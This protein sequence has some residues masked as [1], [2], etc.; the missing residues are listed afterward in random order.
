MRTT[1]ERLARYVVEYPAEELPK[2]T[3]EMARRALLDLLGCA[4]AGAP[5]SSARAARHVAARL[6]AP[7]R[8]RVWFGR[9]PLVPAGAAFANASAASALDLDDGH[10]RAGGHPGASIIPAVL[11]AAAETD[12]SADQLLAAIALGYEIGIRIAAARDFAR[13]D[14][15]SSGRWCGIAA[16]AAAAYLGGLDAAETAE[17]MAIAGV[18]AP[19]LSASG[20]SRRMGNSVKEGIPWATA[21]GLA[22]VEL[23]REG[24]TGPTDLLDHQDYF[25]ADAV[26][27]GLG[28]EAAIE[29]IYFK[30]YG[31]CRWI[32]A[33]LDAVLAIRATPGYRPERIER[34]EVETFARA[35]RLSNETAPTTLEGAQ[36][37]LPFCVAAAAQEG[38]APFLP[39]P[40]SLLGRGD[41]AALAERVAIRVDPELDRRFPGEAPARVRI[42]ADGKIHERTVHAALGD[43]ANPMDEDALRRKFMTLAT[44]VPTRKAERLVDAVLGLE[45]GSTSALFDAIDGVLADPLD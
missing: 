21:L 10:R 27:A 43:P 14:T 19:G 30:P 25:D 6:Y 45:G 40:A 23:A 1:L 35:L 13:L 41:L 8:A 32:H 11:A 42:H 28:G 31:C 18:V 37:S 38:A 9:D 3:A 4:V 2:T 44:V 26:M 33:A 22:A 20:Y 16:A 36:Y 34:I 39:L 7:G 12:P 5:L 17:A 29:S 24:Y 15:L